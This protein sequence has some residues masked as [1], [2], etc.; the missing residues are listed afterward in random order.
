M[1]MKAAWAVLAVALSMAVPVG[2]RVD[3]ADQAGYSRYSYVNDCNSH[4]QNG[5]LNFCRA[6]GSYYINVTTNRDSDLRSQAGGSYQD[7]WLDNFV[8]GNLNGVASNV[9][10]WYNLFPSTTVSQWTGTCYSGSSLTR[11]PGTGYVPN[12]S[13]NLRSIARSDV[14]SC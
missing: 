2:A 10:F 14:F 9:S 13:N 1:K 8:I 4:Y 5:Y 12:S 6:N 3:A 7:K 11:G